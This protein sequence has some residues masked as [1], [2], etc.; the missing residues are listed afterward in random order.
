MKIVHGDSRLLRWLPVLALAAAAATQFGCGNSLTTSSNPGTAGQPVTFTAF[1]GGSPVPQGTVTFMDAG[2]SLATVALDGSGA[3]AYTTTAL[4]AGVH[5][6][7]EHYSG[8][9]FNPPSNSN[10]VLQIINPVPVGFS[11]ATPCRAID[12]RQ[13][14]GPNG[15]PALSANS[16]RT[17]VL[18]GQCG[19]P[20]SAIAL[21]VNVTV[22]QPTGPGD[23]RFTRGG[24]F[25]TPQTSTINYKS[26]QTRANN[27]IVWLGTSGDIVVHCE[28]ASGGVHLVVDVSGYFQ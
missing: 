15:G 19:I 26:G 9:P 27:A 20:S 1:V 25:P 22:T 8:D 18:A 24:G 2:V 4:T 23:L 13:A 10:T 17:F 7:S 21:A 16:D 11:F 5:P 14:A 28:Q 6:I 3:A 12:T